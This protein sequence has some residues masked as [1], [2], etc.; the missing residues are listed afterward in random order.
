MCPVALG[1]VA[2]LV[3]WPLGLGPCS[4][5]LLCPHGSSL[6]MLSAAVTWRWCSGSLVDVASHQLSLAVASLSPLLFSIWPDGRAAHFSLWDGVLSL[7]VVSEAT[8]KAR[9]LEKAKLQG[10]LPWTTTFAQLCF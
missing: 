9:E 3:P 6:L 8:Q 1:V 4:A 5:W 10:H 2:V 7:G